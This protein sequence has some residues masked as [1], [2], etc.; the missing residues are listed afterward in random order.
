MAISS[1]LEHLLVRWLPRQRWMPAL[2]SRVGAEPDVTPQS[3]VRITEVSDGDTGT[4]QCLLV[5]L[6]VRGPLR[7]TRLCVPLTVR[8]V[9]D[10]SL[11]PHLVGTV[12]D[13]LLGKSYVYDG[14]ADPVFV[15]ALADAIADA[16]SGSGEEFQSSL[17]GDELPLADTQSSPLPREGRSPAD[18]RSHDDYGV[19]LLKRA[20]EHRFRRT[21]GLGSESRVEIDGPDGTYALTIL[22]EIGSDNPPAVRYPLALTAVES[23]TVHPVIGWSHTRWYDD[24]DLT[25]ITAPFALLAH[26]LPGSRRAWRSAAEKVLVV[27]SG[28]V[29]SFNRQ[30]SVLGSVVG[31]LHV[32]LAAEFGRVRGEGDPTR[33]LVR[34]WRERV[35]WALN[36]AP[37]ALSSL[38]GRLRAHADGLDDLESIGELQRIHGELTLDHITV[39]TA[40]GPRVIG[41]GVGR[42]EPRPVEI[43][44]VAMVRSIDYAAGYAWLQRSEAL[45]DAEP[46]FRTLATHGLEEDLRDDYLDAPEHLWYRQTANSLLSGYSH[47][48]G[49]TTALVDPVLRAA[50]IDRL[51]VEVVSE[52]RNRPAWLIVPLAALV[53]TLGVEDTGVGDTGVSDMKIS[54]DA[55]S[56][57]DAG[58]AASAAADRA[59]DAAPA[60]DESLRVDGT[61]DEG[62]EDGIAAGADVL[63]D[64]A[65][66][67]DDRSRLTAQVDGDGDGENADPSAESDPAESD[68]AEVPEVGVA[69]ASESEATEL[70]G[71][72][73]P[74]GEP[75]TARL[76]EDS[77]ESDRRDDPVPAASAPAFPRIPAKPAWSP[78]AA[79]GPAAERGLG[80]A[81]A[82]DDGAGDGGAD[83]SADDV[84]DGS[85]SDG[86]DDEAIDEDGAG[87]DESD[88]AAPPRS[89]RTSRGSAD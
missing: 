88:A 82:D 78:S 30:A 68:P 27:D 5:V 70:A 59:S 21:E 32:D 58:T 66:L 34:K 12:D 85:V 15:L 86:I 77:D 57:G 22:R 73:D 36:R 10:F 29:G 23:P 55:S 60:D 7:H 74:V 31:R 39:G 48:R 80:A 26:A 79:R 69:D 3:V 44:L 18:Q 89:A 64:R 42:D 71:P 81:G 52:L 45:A 25:T 8:T 11:R 43:D 56:A 4:V 24:A 65:G 41:F 2:G 72:A 83:D 50:L 33:R 6:T 1:D 62:D 47:A 46:R 19:S 51:L 53:E 17:A 63:P 67:D 20:R 13:L 84:D 49:E 38:E 35:E 54:A 76:A 87:D 28:S 37:G 75:G 14:A 40:E 61:D 16:R 9:E